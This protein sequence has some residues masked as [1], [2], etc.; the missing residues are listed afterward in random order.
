MINAWDQHVKK[1]YSASRVKVI[2]KT[3]F[4]ESLAQICVERCLLVISDAKDNAYCKYSIIDLFKCMEASCLN[5]SM[6]NAL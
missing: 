3:Y 5:I 2:Q 1:A 4:V 6:L